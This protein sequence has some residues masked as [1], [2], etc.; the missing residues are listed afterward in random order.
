MSVPRDIW[1]LAGALAAIAASVI[2]YTALH[3]ANP[4]IVAFTFLLVILVVAATS[5]LG[6]GDRIN[7]RDVGVQFFLSAAGRYVLPR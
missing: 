3:I 5:V 6:G 2:A 7:R 1:F 4:V